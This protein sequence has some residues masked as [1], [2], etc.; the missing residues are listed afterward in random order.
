[1]MQTE[2]GKANIL[3]LIYFGLSLLRVRC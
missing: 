2:H 3:V 1:M